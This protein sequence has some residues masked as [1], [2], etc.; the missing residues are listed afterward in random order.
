MVR[1]HWLYFVPF[2]L[3]PDDLNMTAVS[4]ST[5]CAPVFSQSQKDGLI[6]DSKLAVVLHVSLHPAS[7]PGPAD[8]SSS[9]LWAYRISGCR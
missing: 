5:P 3:Y 9:L 1:G 8:T 7:R 2:A 4:G 6:G